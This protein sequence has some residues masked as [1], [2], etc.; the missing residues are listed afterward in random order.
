MR[1]YCPPCE[2]LER[3]LVGGEHLG[4][5]GCALVHLSEAARR[6]SHHL[7]AILRVSRLVHLHIEAI[8][9]PR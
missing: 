1:L 6:R 7:L 9:V 3:V 8:F 2:H 5:L 4:G